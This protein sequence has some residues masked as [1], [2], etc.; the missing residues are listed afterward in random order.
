MGKVVHFEIPFDDKARAMEFYS[1]CFGWQLADMPEMRTVLLESDE[2]D[3]PYKIRSVG[4]APLL[5]VAPAIANAVRNATGVRYKDLPLTPEKV[6]AGLRA[7]G[8]S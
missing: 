5:A 4:E 1:S 3:G 6:L 7:K 2:G 8:G